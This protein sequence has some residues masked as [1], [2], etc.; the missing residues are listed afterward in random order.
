M[1]PSRPL[2]QVPPRPN[3]R[4]DSFEEPLRELPEPVLTPRDGAILLLICGL[5]W[6]VVAGLFYWVWS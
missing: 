1:K 5:V 6:A 3:I 2:S 4:L